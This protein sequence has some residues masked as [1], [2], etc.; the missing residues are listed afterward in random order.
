M[1]YLKLLQQNETNVLESIQKQFSITLNGE[2]PAD[3][4]VIKAALKKRWEELKKGDVSLE[5]LST[6]ES[7]VKYMKDLD[8][9]IKTAYDKH[10]KE[11]ADH[12]SLIHDHFNNWA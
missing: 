11:I 6:F 8:A 7:Q 5:A 3:F 12:R 1:K 4:L 10:Q 2:Y 9:I